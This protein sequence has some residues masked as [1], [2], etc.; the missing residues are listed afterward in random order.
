MSGYYKKNSYSPVNRTQHIGAQR[1]ECEIFTETSGCL[2]ARYVSG[3]VG[4]AMNAASF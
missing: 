1:A 2:I 3:K 4:N